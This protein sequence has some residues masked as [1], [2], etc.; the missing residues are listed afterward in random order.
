MLGGVYVPSIYWQSRWKLPQ[1]IRVLH[2]C[3]YVMSVERYLTLF[4]LWSLSYSLSVIAHAHAHEYNTIIEHVSTPV[5]TVDNRRIQCTGY[6]YTIIHCYNV[7]KNKTKQKKQ[8]NG[9]HIPLY[10]SMHNNRCFGSY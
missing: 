6:A 1:A 5:P 4:C 3:V 7:K 2:S 9:T 10:L 8:K